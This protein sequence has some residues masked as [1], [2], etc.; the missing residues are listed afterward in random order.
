M[1]IYKMKNHLEM[2]DDEKITGLM[3]HTMF[4]PT[5]GRIKSALEGTYGKEQGKLYVCEIED[6]VGLLGV[7]RVDNA[8]VEIMHFAVDEAHRKKGIAK[9]LLEYVKSAERVNEILAHADHATKDFYQ[10]LGFKIK[11]ELDP[12]TDVIQYVCRMK[13]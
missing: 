13:G 11:E 3:R 5:Y 2:I 7:R 6:I 9:A 8:F 1:N 12:V 4:N 10:A